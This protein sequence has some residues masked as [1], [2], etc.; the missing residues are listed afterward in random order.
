MRA[1]IDT[2]RCQGH[3]RCTVICPEV[4]ELDELGAGVVIHPEV[5]AD[6]RDRAQQAAL[7][8]PERAITVTKE[9]LP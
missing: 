7:N 6:F 5:P 4:F 2:D 1:E 3:G 8:C 9:E